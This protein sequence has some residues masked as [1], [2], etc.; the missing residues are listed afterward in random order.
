MKRAG[1]VILAGAM[2]LAGSMTPAGAVTHAGSAQNSPRVAMLEQ[3][4]WR[5]ITAGN[6]QAATDAF[7]EAAKLDPKN[8][9]LWFGAGTA[10]FLQRHDAEASVHLQHALGLDPKLTRAR[11]QLAQV[12]KRQGDLVEAIRLYEIVSAEIP[13]DR[14]VR[15]ILER[16][17][18][19]RDL[20]ERMR[21][22]VGDH[23]TVSFEGPEDAAMAAQAQESLNRAFWR[24]CDALGAFPGRSI[25]VVLY[26]SE[27]F[28]D[29]TRSPQWAAA[30]FDGIIRVPMRGAKE[31]GEDLDR[32]FAHEFAHALIRS[33]ATRGLPTWLN[34]GLATVLE[35]DDL[36]WAKARMAKVSRTPT[37]AALSTPFSRLSGAGAQIAY[38]AS[39]LAV[40][41]LLDEAGGAAIT[42][43][44]RD[45][46]A[47]VE[48][49]AAFLHR[50]QKSLADFQASLGP[51]R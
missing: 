6:Y 14:G 19:E 18:R 12:V 7:T 48:F 4:G 30:A 29:I 8:A 2:T 3:A 42:N 35:G 43:L 37:L 17:R 32:V 36:E 47:G 26:S 40:R 38:A 13:D 44:L 45:L 23:F 27:Q 49:D 25:P 50:I 11:A 31:N 5:E 9:M 22:D 24:I 15:D 41:R 46:G 28:R 16:W 34:E 21:L 1:G 39:A 51:G 20:H 33:L 10:E